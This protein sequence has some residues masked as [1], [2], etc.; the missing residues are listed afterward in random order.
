MPTQTFTLPLAAGRAEHLLWELVTSL[1]LQ[2]FK[3][4]NEEHHVAELSHK[5]I[6]KLDG[7]TKADVERAE[8][9][10]KAEAEK[11]L[12]AIEYKPEP[13]TIEIKESLGVLEYRFRGTWGGSTTITI[14][15]S[16]ILTDGEEHEPQSVVTI[17]NAYPLPVNWLAAQLRYA[18]EHYNPDGESI[19]FG[20]IMPE[21]HVDSDSTETIEPP[22]ERPHL[23]N[24]P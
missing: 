1:T 6:W 2:T 18:F 21:D 4:C 20:I 24:R 12:K 5:Q 15:E 7:V 22:I 9:Q 23:R 10:S 17:K 13:D 16:V 14:V 8:V 11:R 3:K 19:Q